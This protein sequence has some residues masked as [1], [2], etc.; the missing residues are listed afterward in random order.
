[1]IP[2]MTTVAS[3][4]WISAPGVV[5][6]AMGMKPNPATSA[7]MRIGRSRTMAASRAASWGSTPSCRRCST[8]LTQ[9]SP[10]STA[11][12]KSAMKP[13]PAEIENGSAADV[14]GEHAAGRGHRH[15]G[16]DQ[17]RQPDRV[18]RAVEQQ[19]DQEHG[20]R[21]DDQQA[22]GR[23]SAGARTGRPSATW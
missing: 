14:E 7:V 1:M 20:H 19:E 12:P 9:T 18:K 10:F 11:T 2:P 22:A 23:P 5:A 16:V 15:G 8:A 4:R 21:H 3:G 13:T 6:M 17:E